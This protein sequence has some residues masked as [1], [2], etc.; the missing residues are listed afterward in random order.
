M[1]Q[2]RV[3]GLYRWPVKSLAGESIHLARLDGRGL[4]GDRSYALTDLRPD[5]TGRVFTVRQNPGVLAWSSRYPDG[6]AADPAGTPL[7]RSPD[8]TEWSWADP[9]LAGVLRRWLGVPVERRAAEGQQ[10]RGPTVLVTFEAS[11]AGLAEQLGGEVDIRRFRPNLHLETDAP[12]FA[13]QDWAAGTSI[14]AGA[15]RLEVVGPGA[16]PCIR[17]TVPSWDPTGRERWPRLQACLIERHGNAFG[18]IMRVTGP[19]TVRTGDP[20]R[21]RPVPAAG[22]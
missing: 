18:L 20:V 7:L 4:A 21:A 2:G 11:R 14:T 22:G 5:R 12:A 6:A 3:R 16:G 19:G 8:G 15:A 9:D 1:H 17:C 10:D 13:E